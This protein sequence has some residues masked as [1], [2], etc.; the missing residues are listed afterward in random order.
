MKQKNSFE[1]KRLYTRVSTDIPVII[2][3]CDT[4]IKV[5]GTNLC[6]NGLHCD[7]YVHFPCNTKVQLA[8]KL[9]NGKNGFEYLM[10]NGVIIRVKEECFNSK[11]RKIYK[12]AI[13]FEELLPFEKSIL[14]R[15]VSA[16][17]GE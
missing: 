6:S 15:Y 3:A 7:S 8:F 5:I 14:E 17:K 9:P 12:I 16:E 2:K 10:F 4:R 1:E 13:N 11:G